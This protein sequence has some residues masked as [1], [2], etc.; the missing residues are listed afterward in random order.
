MEPSPKQFEGIRWR[1][2]IR[3]ISDYKIAIG[4]ERNK[5]VGEFELYR[6][7]IATKAS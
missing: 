3:K 7:R 1:S 6:E 4:L 2:Y 5:E